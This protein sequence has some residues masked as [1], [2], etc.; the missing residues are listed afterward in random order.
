M[1]KICIGCGK[2]FEVKHRSKLICSSECAKSRKNRQTSLYY[3]TITKEITQEVIEEQKGKQIITLAK[4]IG[5]HKDLLSWCELG[6]HTPSDWSKSKM[7]WRNV[8]FTVCLPKT[9][10]TPD[11]T[12]LCVF[13]A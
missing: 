3:K 5:G 6:T 13:A 2:E 9:K 4:H 1:T 11:E 12:S 10:G 7:Y 8:K